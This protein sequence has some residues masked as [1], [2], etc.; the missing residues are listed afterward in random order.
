[1]IMRKIL[2]STALMLVISVGANAQL[3]PE[4]V[5][6][7]LPDLPTLAQMIAYET[8][9]QNPD[10]YSDFHAKLN[11][12]Q[13]KCQEMVDK[14]TASL[15]FDVKSKAMKE[16]VPGTKTKVAQALNMSKSQLQALAKSSAEGRVASMGVS[17]AD[18]QSVQSGKMS[19]EELANKILA[20]RTGGLN[21]KDIEA[22]SNMS[23]A[24][25][26]E[27]IQNSGLSASTQAAAAK[28]SKAAA[29]NAALTS[30][31]QKI[32]SL[33]K[34]IGELTQKSIRLRDEGKAFGKDL[35]AKEYAG[36]IEPLREEYRALSV[37]VG[38]GENGT[39]AEEAKGKEAS[40]KIAAIDKQIDGFMHDFY[41]K[42][43][44]VWRN[45][46]VAS[47]DVFR[48]E[49]LPLQYELKE[50]YAKAYELTG[51]YEYMGGDQF[52]FSAAFSYLESAEY[53]DDY[54]F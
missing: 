47:M 9:E 8:D 17:M 1:M 43:L 41:S 15:A 3:T 13:K 30:V 42:A 24:E 23:D 39:S 34:R 51:S 7:T 36:K 50:A 4:G 28:N 35:Y 22:M 46:V 11:D 40:T 16:N 38:G 12:A 52:P 29:G 21:M 10:L 32:T 25:R 6:A 44:P 27:F 2:I 18:I 19:E 53:I 48:T 33:Q 49:V 31:T 14:G 5:M 54:N 37:F 20:Q 26:I 45:A